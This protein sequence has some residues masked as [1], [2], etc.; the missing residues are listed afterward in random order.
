MYDGDIGR[1]SLIGSSWAQFL[2]SGNDQTELHT[3]PVRQFGDRKTVHHETS[4]IQPWRCLLLLKGFQ[5][6]GHMT[7]S[8]ENNQSHI[9]NQKHQNINTK[10]KAATAGDFSAQA[11][12]T[13]FQH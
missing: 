2:L 13:D 5:V 9:V 1:P 11:K 3:S 8:S 10:I 6:A 7:R 12:T 4:G